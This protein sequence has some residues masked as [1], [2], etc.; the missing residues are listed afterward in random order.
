[1]YSGSGCLEISPSRYFISITPVVEDSKMAFKVL[2]R[3]SGNG[4]AF[5]CEDFGA[6]R[7]WTTLL[8]L[9]HKSSS[10]IGYLSLPVGTTLCLQS[11]MIRILELNLSICSCRNLSQSTKADFSLRVLQLLNRISRGIGAFLKSR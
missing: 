9:E 6:I 4:V 11:R 3:I 1:M 8:D 7:I 5:C 2:A 10:S